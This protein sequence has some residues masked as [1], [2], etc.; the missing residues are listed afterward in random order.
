M[1]VAF[2]N[3]IFIF[4]SSSFQN[5]V[6]LFPVPIRFL[7][8]SESMHIVIFS[9]VNNESRSFIGVDIKKSQHFLMTIFICIHNEEHA[10]FT[11][12]GWKKILVTLKSFTSQN[13]WTLCFTFFLDFLYKLRYSLYQFSRRNFQFSRI[14]DFFAYHLLSPRHNS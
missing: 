6:Q 9:I 8:I 4:S 5:I 13:Q 10:I 1:I 2:R 12:S 14:I 3:D 7:H 11:M